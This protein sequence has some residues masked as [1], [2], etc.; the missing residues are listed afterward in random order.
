MNKNEQIL[1]S[2]AAEY[3]SYADNVE[4]YTRYRKDLKV[5][6]DSTPVNSPLILTK[7]E[8]ARDLTISL[9]AL[10]LSRLKPGLSASATEDTVRDF[11]NYCYLFA[12]YVFSFSEFRFSEFEFISDKVVDDELEHSLIVDILSILAGK[13]YDADNY[14]WILEYADLVLRKLQ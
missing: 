3:G 1:K 2:R 13:S 10:K 9:A 4:L 8:N 14:K 11:F 12:D 5:G 7:I 6:F